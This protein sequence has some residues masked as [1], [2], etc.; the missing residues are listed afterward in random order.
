MSAQADNISAG[1]MNW[2]DGARLAA[3]FCII[4]IHTSSDR[5]GGAFKNAEG[6]DRVFPVLMRSVSEMAS[7]EFFILVSLFLL[8]MKLSK[9][10]TPFIPTMSLQARR[11]LVPFVFWTVFYAL[12]RFYKGHYL[13]YEQAILDQIGSVSSWVG[14][15]VLGNANFHMH[16]LPTLFM[17]LLFHRL[18][19][20]A[21]P[22]PLLGLLVIPMLYL[23]DSIGGWI[24]ATIKDPMLREYVV[25]FVKILTYTGYGFF[26]YALYGFWQRGMSTQMAK[27]L[28]GLCLFMV[29]LGL[30]VKLIYAQKVG[31]SGDFV[32]RRDMIF[33]GHYLLPCAMLAAFMC[34]WYLRWPDRLSQWSKFSFGMY[35]IHPAI[36][37]V[38]DVA[39][40]SISVQPD[41]YVLIKYS[42]TAFLSLGLT[43]AIGRISLIAWTVGLG[44]LPSFGRQEMKSVVTAQ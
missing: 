12:F 24:W 28:F 2:L 22:Y 21:I 32:V 31:V 17:L 14:Y 23:N 25:R 5:L 39:F 3:A 15:F 33:Y 35:L 38:L 44:P 4:G 26:A 10:A 20:L 13:G 40:L 41:W 7:T 30:L 29:S 18:Y 34:S 1:R 37:D 36:M 19:K 9:S 27:T 42:A 16:F 6:H 11:L 43:M 8:S